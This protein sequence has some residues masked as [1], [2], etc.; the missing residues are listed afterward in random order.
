MELSSGFQ[1]GWRDCFAMALGLTFVLGGCSGTPSRVAMVEVDADDAAAHA[2]AAYDTN[3]DGKLSDEELRA[4]PG[5]HKWKQHY[6]TDGDGAVAEAEV[7]AR[8]KKWQS[9]KLAFRSIGARVELNGRP[10][11][12]VEVL[13]IPEQYLGPA[14]KAAKGVTNNRGNASLSVAP[15]DLPT[16]IK[17]RGIAV[18]GVYPGTYRIELKRAGGNLPSTSR[19]GLPLGDEVARDT[20]DTTIRIDLATTK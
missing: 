1:N 6:D 20:V 4:V 13:L 19:D 14:F 10:V 16:A 2:M 3:K 15:E 11:P 8:I 17:A 18:E 5:I 7:V 12:G 9:D